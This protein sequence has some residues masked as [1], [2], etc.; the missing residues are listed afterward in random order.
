MRASRFSGMIVGAGMA[1]FAAVGVW[2]E[3][4]Y[5]LVQIATQRQTRMFEM[6]D[7]YWPLFKLASGK[8]DD[9]SVVPESVTKIG[10]DIDAFLTLL[11]PG[12]SGDD[13]PATRARPE[14]WTDPEPF[15]EAA[16]QLKA[17]G[18]KLVEVA[19]TGDMAAYNEQFEL[20][21][22]YCTACHGFLPSS[23]GP[24]RYEK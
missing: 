11:P 18:A 6:L 4:E 14:I 5:E 16:E 10:D 8:T 3:T 24:Y 2:A 21:S 9:L 13:I 23:G 17:E 7:A 12:S 22:I 1:S 15:L 19:A 20:F